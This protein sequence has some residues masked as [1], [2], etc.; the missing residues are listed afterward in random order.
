MRF[1]RRVLVGMHR[2][3]SKVRYDLLLLD[4]LERITEQN[5]S[6]DRLYNNF[7]VVSSIL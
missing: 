4:I 3:G 6:P 5:I 2:R 1:D 7:V